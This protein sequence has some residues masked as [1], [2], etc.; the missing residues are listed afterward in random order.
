MKERVHPGWTL[1]CQVMGADS[2]GFSR[3]EV[4]RTVIKNVKPLLDA[5]E[6]EH[7]S[8]G[9]EVGWHGHKDET[10]DVCCL[11]AAWSAHNLRVGR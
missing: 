7:S 3:D 4:T 6:S 11:L 8:L 10:C 9:S 2:M 5:L 1:A